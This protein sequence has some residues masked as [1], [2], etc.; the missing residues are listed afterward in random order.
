MPTREL[1]HPV[2]VSVLVESDDGA[3]HPRRSMPRRA[4]SRVVLGVVWRV[5]GPR[6]RLAPRAT[7]GAQ[8]SK[9][10]FDPTFRDLLPMLPT[11]QPLESVEAIRTARASRIMM[12]PAP[13]DREDVVKQDY[14]VP[15]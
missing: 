8:M 15:G 6:A 2:R 13:P 12:F 5:D 4:R 1:G 11:T 7:R 14:Q 9:Y 3:I 10:E